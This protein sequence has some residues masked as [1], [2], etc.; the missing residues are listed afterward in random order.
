MNETIDHLLQEKRV[1]AP[2]ADF[3]TQANVNDDTPYQEAEKDRLAY[4]ENWAKQLDWF[5]PWTKTLEWEPPYSKWFV[6]GKLNACYNCVDRHV[7]N[8]LGD[9]TALIWEG[10][11]GD[12]RN[13]TYA[14]LLEEVSKFA[15]ALKDLGVKKGDRVAL[16]MPMIPELAIAVLACARIGA[17]HSVVFGGFSATSLADR[18][19]DQ[20]AKALITTDAGW[21]RGKVLPLKETCDEALKT[22]PSIEHCIVVK[23]MTNDEVKVDMKEGRDVWYHDLMAKASA[24]C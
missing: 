21:R 5:E 15:N 10:E 23:R 6:G 12:R 8:G 3:K 4:W 18:I 11:P 7:K 19:I 14:D 1:F 22:C 17:P 20:E 24:D 2:S 9:K 16:Y 13:L